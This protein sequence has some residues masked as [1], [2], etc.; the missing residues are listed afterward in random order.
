M[1]KNIIYLALYLILAWI[2]LM[3]DEA[4][5]RLFISVSCIAITLAVFYYLQLDIPNLSIT[6]AKFKYLAY[7]AG[8]MFF[9]A[10]KVSKIAWS[11]DINLNPT[12]L[13]INSGQYSEVAK[14]VYGNSITLTPGTI[15]IEIDD[16]N[17]LVHAL[18]NEF[19]DDLKTGEMEQKV[20]SSFL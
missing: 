6:R 9:S 1:P 14:T 19:M 17:F 15:T 11:S 18:D 5:S 12:M 3:L 2:I 7:L 16:N 8:E 13:W 20:R 10:I 4:V